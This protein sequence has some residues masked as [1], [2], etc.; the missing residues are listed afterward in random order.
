[1]GNPKETFRCEVTFD[2]GGKS[3]YA[4]IENLLEFISFI[5]GWYLDWETIKVY[6]ELS[7]D[8]VEEL[9]V[10]D[11]LEFEGIEYNPEKWVNLDAWDY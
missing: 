11:Y 1:M 8:F 6:S 3:S 5:H 9:Q 2:S 10:D 4:N 7:G